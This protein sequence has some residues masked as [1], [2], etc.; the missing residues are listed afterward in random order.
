M[1]KMSDGFSGERSVVLPDVARRAS[2]SD[3]LVSQLFITDIGYYPHASYHYRERTEGVDQYILIYCMKGSG[4]YGV[5]GKRFEV[6]G[7]QYFIIPRGE[8]HV[9]A[10]HNADPWT[11]YWVHFAGA[12]APLFGQGTLAPTTLTPGTTS[13]I[14]DRNA[15]FEEIFLTLSDNYS[16]DNLRYASSL[17]HAFLASFRFL[18]HYRRYNAQ[19]ERIDTTDIVAMAVRYMNE[20]LERK[21]TLKELAA[22]LGYSVSQLSLVFRN[23]TGHSPLNYFNLLKIQR[24]CQLLET[25]GLKVNQ[26]SSKVG[27]D[28]SY[29]FSRLFA[30]VV[31]IS[32]RAYRQGARKQPAGG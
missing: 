2:E 23:R 24:A 13:R 32:P 19:Q 15:L 7:N 21:L 27:I 5:R 3:P 14:G 10:S 9:Y 18:R 31:G 29:Y 30:K 11:I 28:D 26:I 20:N 25:T 8:P 4:W 22:Y 12:L 16:L 1:L 6:S 17:L